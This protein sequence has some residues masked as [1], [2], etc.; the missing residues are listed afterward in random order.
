[1]ANEQRAKYDRLDGAVGS[2]AAV[3]VAEPAIP[4]TVVSMDKDAMFLLQRSSASLDDFPKEFHRTDAF[5]CPE[6]DM[7]PVERPWVNGKMRMVNLT[8]ADV[9]TQYAYAYLTVEDMKRMPEYGGYK[10]VRKDAEGSEKIPMRYFAT[11]GLI[12]AGSEHVLCVA[13]RSYADTQKAVFREP[14]ERQLREASKLDAPG[15]EGVTGSQKIE[16]KFDAG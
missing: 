9:N 1:M 8:C 15:G 4:A 2:G 5:S 6:M 11:D 16:S 13:S 3:G 7:P 14:L 10:P 12:H